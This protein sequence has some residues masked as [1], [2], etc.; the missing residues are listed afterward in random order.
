MQWEDRQNKQVNRE[1]K[2]E[3]EQREWLISACGGAPGINI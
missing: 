2:N 1:E 3:R